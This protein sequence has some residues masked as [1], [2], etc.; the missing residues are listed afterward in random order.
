[1]F[2]SCKYNGKDLYSNHWDLCTVEEGM[3]NRI[4]YCPIKKGHKKYL[5]DMPIPNYLPKVSRNF[6]FWSKVINVNKFICCFF[7]W[8]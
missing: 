6:F 5:K 8:Y 4:I 7:S 2:I 3:S 1:M